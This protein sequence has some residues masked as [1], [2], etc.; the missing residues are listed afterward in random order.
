MRFPSLL[1]STVALCA[2]PLPLPAQIVG[3][4]TVVLKKV[5]GQPDQALGASLAALPDLDHDGRREILVGAPGTV[6]TARPGQAFLVS[7]GSGSVLR[8]FSEGGADQHFGE[9]LAY[10]GDLD[11]DGGP[12]LAIATQVTDTHPS[13]IYTYRARTGA[14]LSRHSLRPGEACD[15]LAAAGDFDGDGADDLLFSASDTLSCRWGVLSGRT[16]ALLFEEVLQTYG[17]NSFE[18]FRVGDL[19]G[20]G[21]RDFAVGDRYADT[22]LYTNVGQVTVHSGADGSALLFVHGEGSHDKFG[23]SVAGTGDLDGDGVP[24]LLVGATGTSSFAMGWHGSA[25]L[26]S[27]ADGRVVWRRDGEGSSHHLG[28]TVISVGDFDGDGEEDLAA[29]APNFQLESF[30]AKGAVYVLRGS[31]GRVL[32]RTPGAQGDHLGHGLIAA[33]DLDRDGLDDLVASSPYPASSGG[34]LAG[35]GLDPYLHPSAGRLS[36]SAGAP[37]EF[38]IDFPASEGGHS[39]LVLASAAGTGPTLEGRLEIPLTADTLYHRLKAGG[40]GAVLQHGHGR[41][42]RQGDARAALLAHPSLSGFAGQ[43]LAFAAISYD[44]HSGEGRLSSI[45]R[46]VTILP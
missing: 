46:F 43:T 23:T 30:W 42:S 27:G 29:G 31:D 21:H 34:V 24:D 32:S 19:D 7:P 16:G 5:Y 38:G 4:E 20:D 11:G 22:A 26:I 44:R 15:S 12:D 41:L 8:A 35:I 2:L 37:V 45:A 40:G 13:T 36:L 3:G 18:V 33:G 28:R 6:S 9:V 17:A 25:Y 1:L 14:A 10:A 39:Y